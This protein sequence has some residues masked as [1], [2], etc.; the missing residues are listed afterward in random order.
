MQE[1]G[2]SVDTDRGR[3]NAAVAVGDEKT[4]PREE[5]YAEYS[6][7][8]AGETDAVSVE[9]RATTRYTSFKLLHRAAK[10]SLGAAVRPLSVVR[11]GDCLR[12]RLRVAERRAPQLNAWLN[13]LLLQPRGRLLVRSFMQFDVVAQ[14]NLRPAPRAAPT[15]VVTAPP[16][17]VAATPSAA[18]AAAPVAAAAPPPAADADAYATDE[19]DAPPPAEEAA[20]RA[21]DIFASASE[22]AARPSEADVAA[23]NAA[24]DLFAV[25]T[26][27]SREEFKEELDHKLFGQERTKRQLIDLLVVQQ[28]RPA[29][30]VTTNHFIIQG[31][32]GVGKTTLG[33]FITTN[34]ARHGV[35][36]RDHMEQATGTS[37]TGEHVGTTKVKVEEALAKAKG[38]VLL[39]D[40]AY[41]LADNQYGKEAVA[42][43][44]DRMTAPGDP[45]VILAG[46][47]EKMQ[48]FLD[49]NQG[50]RRRIGTTLTLD[51]YST[52]EL[53]E[54][55][56]LRTTPGT[57]WF[58]ATRNPHGLARAPRGWQLDERVTK[59]EVGLFFAR[60]FP[61]KEYNSTK[62][63]SLVHGVAGLSYHALAECAA[64][65]ARQTAHEEARGTVD[66]YVFQAEH[67]EEATKQSR[68]VARRAICDE[69][70]GLG[71]RELRTGAEARSES[72]I[73]AERARLQAQLDTL[74][75]RAAVGAAGVR[76]SEPAGGGG[77]KQRA[78]YAV[79]AHDFDGNRYEARGGRSWSEFVQLQKD[80]RP[81]LGER[82]P[83]LSDTA[84]KFD[85]AAERAAQRVKTLDA[86]LAEVLRSFARGP[87]EE[88]PPRGENIQH[89]LEV[90][91]LQRFLGMLD[92]RLTR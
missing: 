30:G 18:A 82:T 48:R 17:M 79:T 40:E 67:L 72:E 42:V 14:R 36:K 85:S 55:F 9:M 24:E 44:L 83:A 12:N 43:L 32:P 6:I 13:A 90:L 38:G 27:R 7:I 74:D 15:P 46:Y 59:M 81:Y 31:S 66:G 89:V 37:L 68:R 28:Q 41:T 5:R 75:F 62:N 8:L 3:W 34:L 1:A 47:P 84:N 10:L 23:A 45:L 57:V 20:P 25:A 56:W 11:Y 91:P 58:D 65:N 29:V 63:G 39:I 33:R 54:M 71:D 76:A 2:D 49:V 92:D 50:L 77:A 4:G 87:P 80:L 86:W 69:L 73:A 70:R 52:A 53:A 26:W 88:A 60:A 35:I 19:G 16:P 64:A 21:A 22:D 51:D 78:F 61:L